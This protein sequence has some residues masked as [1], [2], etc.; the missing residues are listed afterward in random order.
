MAGRTLACALGIG[1]AF[2]T[3]HSR[4]SRRTPQPPVSDLDDERGAA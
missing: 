3:Y 1:A 2:R 4:A